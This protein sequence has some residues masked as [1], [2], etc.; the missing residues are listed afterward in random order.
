MH[1]NLK[2][3]RGVKSPSNRLFRELQ[4]KAQPVV[5][6]PATR[7]AEYREHLAANNRLRNSLIASGNISP[8]KTN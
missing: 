8:V 2:L 3:G 5:I 1:N 6:D 7:F 4:P